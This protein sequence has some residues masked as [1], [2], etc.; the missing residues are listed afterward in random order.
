MEH[1]PAQNSTTYKTTLAQFPFV[2]KLKR[3]E[4]TLQY[5]NAVV[6]HQFTHYKIRSML[7]K[8]QQHIRWSVSSSSFLVEG[9]LSIRTSLTRRPSSDSYEIWRK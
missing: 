2:T 9:K 8:I 6:K 1:V 7:V 4:S 3:G 5:E